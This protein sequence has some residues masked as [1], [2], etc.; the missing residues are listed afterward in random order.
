[1]IMV[2]MTEPSMPLLF[3]QWMMRQLRSY[4][5]WYVVIM[6]LLV[7]TRLLRMTKEQPLPASHLNATNATDRGRGLLL[8][9][10]PLH[11]IVYLNL[12]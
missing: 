11:L 8:C 5:I 6:P 4:L 7:D 2:N 10:D 9:L 1:M 3:L 12:P